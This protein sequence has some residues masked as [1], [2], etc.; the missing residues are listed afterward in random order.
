MVPWW[1]NANS[2]EA[3]V[4]LA[5]TQVNSNRGKKLLA[6]APLARSVLITFPEAI[7]AAVAGL[8]WV[9]FIV[10]SHY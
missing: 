8:V 4:P 5:I 2:I 1:R 7:P 10:H 6:L 3:P 9:S